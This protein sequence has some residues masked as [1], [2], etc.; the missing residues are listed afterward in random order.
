M[1]GFRT[2][3]SRLPAFLPATVATITS[4]HI[5][6]FFFLFFLPSPKIS[7]PFSIPSS[8]FTFIHIQISTL[9]PAPGG[10]VTR[11]TRGW[12]LCS[13]LLSWKEFSFFFFLNRKVCIYGRMDGDGRTCVCVYILYHINIYIHIS[14]PTNER[15]NERTSRSCL[16]CLIYTPTL[17]TSSIPSRSSKQIL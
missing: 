2:T 11:V 3:R 10:H 16:I 17:S 13:S 14:S 9:A 12:G 5:R 4:H 8:L 1:A 6:S 15:T 7:S